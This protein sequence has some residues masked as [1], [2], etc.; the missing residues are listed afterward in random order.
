MISLIGAV[1]CA[2]IASELYTD[3]TIGT[4]HF[5]LPRL[6]KAVALVGFCL[7]TVL[8]AQKVRRRVA[9]ALNI[10]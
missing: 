4:E 2:V 1:S 6:L 8:E 3:L 7:F 5:P 9:A 10:A